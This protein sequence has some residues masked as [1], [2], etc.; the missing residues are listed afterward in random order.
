MISP[1]T[2][3][4]KITVFLQKREPISPDMQCCLQQMHL[5][6]KTVVTV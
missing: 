6:L 5:P 2:V 4:F 1:H 3:T